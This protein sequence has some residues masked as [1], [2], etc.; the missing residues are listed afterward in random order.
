MKTPLRVALMTL[1]GVLSLLAAIT[2]SA[3]EW[4]EVA[5]L[6]TGTSTTP[7]TTH[8]WFIENESSI[9]LEAGHP[10]N[11]WVQDIKKSHKV[12]FASDAMAGDYDIHQR[13]QTT[14]ETIRRL[15][16]KK[17]GWR[18]WWISLIFDTSQSYLIE[19]TPVIE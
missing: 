9:Y 6:T 2:Y 15:M 19:L 3:L 7:R 18:D 1:A 13:D 17:Y 16:R 12:H 14:H 5:Y 10:D 4:D 11:P 8:V